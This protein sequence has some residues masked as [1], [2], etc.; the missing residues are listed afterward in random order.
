MSD[1]ALGKSLAE[2]SKTEVGTPGVGH[3]SRPFPR[4]HE[5]LHNIYVL[6]DLHAHGHRY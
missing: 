6:F 5:V 4:V 1:P 2:L 3:A